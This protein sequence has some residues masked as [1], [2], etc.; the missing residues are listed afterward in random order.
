[1]GCFRCDNCGALNIAIGKKWSDSDEDP[2]RW[3]ARKRNLEWKPEPPEEEPAWEFP[4][5]PPDIAD[6]AAEAYVCWYRADANRGAVIVARAV[7]EATAKD[8]GITKGRLIEKIDAM[9]ALIRPHVRQGAHEIRLLGN[10]M[11]HG[12]LAEHVTNED[13]ELVLRLM[14]EVLDDVYQ[15]PARVAR[16][17]AARE[18]RKQQ[19]LY[20]AALKEG[21]L[22]S[23]QFPRL[24]PMTMTSVEGK[25]SA[26]HV[27]RAADLTDGP[28]DSA[29]AR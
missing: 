8:K 27:A 7:I 18:A 28:S 16:A 12:D 5:V 3:L 14:S 15:S 2:L 25:L 13:A 1:M 26:G 9:S 20:L 4:D 23:A 17:K 24:K 21:K 11:A 22:P 6:A 10:D 29:E 19:Q